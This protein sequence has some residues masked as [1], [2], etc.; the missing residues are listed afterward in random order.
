M[1]A[2]IVHKK[3]YLINTIEKKV[4]I[5]LNIGNYRMLNAQNEIR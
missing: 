1:I 5:Q 4:I 2:K 3:I